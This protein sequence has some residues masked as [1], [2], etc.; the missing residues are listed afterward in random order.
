MVVANHQHPGRLHSIQTLTILSTSMANNTMTS[1]YRSIMLC[2]MRTFCPASWS[3]RRATLQAV[4]VLLLA[5]ALV[6]C[7]GLYSAAAPE[8][9]VR[10]LATQRWQALMSK[11]FDRAY[12]FAVPAYRQIRSAEYYRNKRLITPV[13]WLAAEVLRVDCEPA[14]CTVRIKLESKPMVPPQFVGNLITAM[15]ETWV[16]EDG[17]WWMFETL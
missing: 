4:P 12:E 15:D 9:Q 16:F 8:L 11:D 3:A 2:A 1:G 17:Q 13:K 5:T 6:G 10:R 7:A 14:K